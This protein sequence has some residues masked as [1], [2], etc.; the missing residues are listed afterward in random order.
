MHG[1]AAGESIVIAVIEGQIAAD[2]R[3]PEQAIG[4]VI[5]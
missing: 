4:L 1:V 3:V 2:L 5:R